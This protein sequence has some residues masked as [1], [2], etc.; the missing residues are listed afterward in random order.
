MNA[1]THL[2]FRGEDREAL[3]FYQSVFGG[4]LTIVTYEDAHN[5]Q[6]PSEANQVTWGQVPPTMASA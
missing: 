1:V 2:N 6:K 3:E 4:N 5:V